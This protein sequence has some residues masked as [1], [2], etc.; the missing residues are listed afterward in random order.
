M[1]HSYLPGLLRGTI[2]RNT[3][4]LRNVSR[5]TTTHGDP[6]DSCRLAV[7]LKVHC[8]RRSVYG[9]GYNISPTS[10]SSCR[11]SSLSCPYPFTMTSK[12]YPRIA[13]GRSSFTQRCLNSQLSGNL[14]YSAFTSTASVQISLICTCKAWICSSESEWQ[15]CSGW[16]LA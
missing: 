11:F 5:C 10:I 2:S 12:P 8:L 7:W 14:R 15:R 3:L 13:K 1:D 16:I 9:L 6:F 4:Q